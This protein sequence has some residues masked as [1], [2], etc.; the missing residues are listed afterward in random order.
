[1]RRSSSRPVGDQSTHDYLLE[2]TRDLFENLY[3]YAVQEPIANWDQP[4]AASTRGLIR[5]RHHRLS[6]RAD[7]GLAYAPQRPL[8]SGV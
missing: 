2:A 6:E 1:M 5:P 4:M 3:L 8:L 7:S